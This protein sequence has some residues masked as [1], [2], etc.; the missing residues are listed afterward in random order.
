ME[1]L[2]YCWLCASVGEKATF[3]TRCDNWIENCTDS[4]DNQNLWYLSKCPKC[5]STW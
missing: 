4:E 3:C 1:D 2:E 5:G